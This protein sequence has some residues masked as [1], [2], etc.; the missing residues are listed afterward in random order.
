MPQYQGIPS[1][2]DGKISDQTLHDILAAMKEDLEI[3]MGARGEG[4]SVT[5][6]T[7]GVVA[8]D[9][10]VMKQI[11]S[12]GDYTTVNTSIQVP[13]LTDYVKLLTDVQQMAVDLA[14]VQLVLNTLIRN[15]KV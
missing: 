7:L 13:V 3:M 11:Q 4:R 2:P 8:K 14:T 6:D 12:R 10:Q 15:M 5:N 1:I 9:W